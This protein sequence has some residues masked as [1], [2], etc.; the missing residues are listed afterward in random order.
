MNGSVLALPRET[1][2]THKI[3]VVVGLSLLTAIGAKIQAPM[4][5]AP[6]TLQTVAVLLGGLWAGSR[7]GAAAQLT[8]LTLGLAGLPVFAGPGAGPAYFV[9][10]TAGFLLAF[11]IC[12][13]VA[14]LG[15]GKPLT[16]RLLATLSGAAV[17]LLV[18]TGWLMLGQGAAVWTSTLPFI[19]G[20]SIKAIAVS[21]AVGLLPP[22]WRRVD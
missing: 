21:V 13:A 2:L 16:C 5:P 12:A 19:F 22:R 17:L 4:W 10:P 1:T 3:A 6:V 18:G 7:L 8:Y 15:T 9:G 20:E 11:P 14:G